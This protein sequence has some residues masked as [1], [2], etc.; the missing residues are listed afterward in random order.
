M[1]GDS[2]DPDVI[3]YPCLTLPFPFAAGTDHLDFVSGRKL[4]AGV[5]ALLLSHS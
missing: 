4:G 1:M 3:A 5:R 2:D